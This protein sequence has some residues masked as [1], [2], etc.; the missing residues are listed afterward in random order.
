MDGGKARVIVAVLVTPAE[1]RDNQPA[2]DLLWYAR[3]RWR[4]FARA[5]PVGCR[6]PSTMLVRHARHHA[7]LSPLTPQPD[8]Y[9][10][11]EQFNECGALPDRFGRAPHS[12]KVSSRDGVAAEVSGGREDDAAGGTGQGSGIIPGAPVARHRVEHAAERVGRRL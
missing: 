8:G 7:Y 11:L 1:V 12:L 5:M 4:L 10:S 9:L 2:A 6:T 3:A